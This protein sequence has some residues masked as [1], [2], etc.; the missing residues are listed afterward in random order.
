M[1]YPGFFEEVLKQLNAPITQN[2]L[3]LLNIWSRFEGGN[4]KFNPLN[5]TK[6]AIGTTD[7]NSA[8]VKNYPDMQTGIDATAKTLKLQYYTPILYAL[9][10]NKAITY[11]YGNSDIVK[12]FNTWGTINLAKEFQKVGNGDVK[13]KVSWLIPFLLIGG[14]IYFYA[15]N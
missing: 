2:N 8:G 14:G 7:F 12:A 4:A 13:K 15:N 1:N 10:N 5:T 11:Y 6:K 9:Q 3:D